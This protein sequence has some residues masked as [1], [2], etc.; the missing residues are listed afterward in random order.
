M[1]CLT[2]ISQKRSRWIALTD[3]DTEKQNVCVCV[4]M[5]KDAPVWVTRRLTLGTDGSTVP[6]RGEV[7]TWRCVGPV[8]A[9]TDTASLQVFFYSFFWG[10]THRPSPSCLTVCVRR[11]CLFNLM[12]S[13]TGGPTRG[14]CCRLWVSSFNGPGVSHAVCTGGVC[15]A[16]QRC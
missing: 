5:C 14:V 11:S 9:A 10:N 8:A 3:I 15:G 6:Q 16:E 13:R 12:S 2:P 1:P 4:C 7:P